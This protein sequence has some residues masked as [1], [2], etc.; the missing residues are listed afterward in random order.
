[1]STLLSL[2]TDPAECASQA[3]L[4]VVLDLFG[5]HLHHPLCR[6]T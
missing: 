4:L 3:V 1:L 2:V 5:G 6:C